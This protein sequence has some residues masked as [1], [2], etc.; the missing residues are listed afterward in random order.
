MTSTLALTVARLSLCVM[1]NDRLGPRKIPTQSA[2]REALR[3][4]KAEERGVGPD[5][6]SDDDDEYSNRVTKLAKE[7]PEY[8]GFV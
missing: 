4:L 6:V 1:F 3:K 7:D 5:E 8:F 2:I